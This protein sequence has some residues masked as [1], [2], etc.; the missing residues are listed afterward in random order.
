[1]Y[2]TA[3]DFYKE[4]FGGKVYKLSVDAGFT[5]P[6]RDG[7]VGVGGCIFCSQN[8]GG[9]FA[10]RGNNILEQ[11][12]KAKARVSK[13]T[14]ENKFIAYFQAFTNTYADINT[15]KKLYY[16]AIS[17]D[18][19]VGLS[20]ATRP[21]CLPPE[22][23]ELLSEINKIKPV[24]I[25]LGFQTSNE[26]TAKYIRRGYKN[27]VYFDAVKRL[28]ENGIDVVTHIIIGLPGED[29]TD[30]INTTNFAVLA[31]TNG[32]KFHLLHVICGTDLEK[33]YLNGKFKTLTLE[34]YADILK[35][36]VDVLPK[37]IVVHRITGDGDKKSLVAPL[38]SADKKTVINYLNKRLK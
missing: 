12:E 15:L 11:L 28:R 5:C 10:E 22:T 21:D 32:V 23:V 20:V 14:K 24:S 27:A 26:E 34:E 16:D 38:W 17:P 6:N 18:Y 2:K 19:I 29:A 37:D 25:E 31:G 1:M 13:K 30:A 36:C 4:K 3:N 33:E 35:N 7:T 8:G 9:E